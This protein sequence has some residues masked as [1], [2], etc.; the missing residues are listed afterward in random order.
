MFR[1][2]ARGDHTHTGRMRW[3]GVL[4]VGGNVSKTGSIILFGR[5][6]GYPDNGGIC[7][8]GIVNGGIGNGGIV[9]IIISVHDGGD[10]G[11]GRGK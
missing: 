9:I 2:M 11:G 5:G 8:G 4:G 6:G 10:G 7:S 1:T 3:R